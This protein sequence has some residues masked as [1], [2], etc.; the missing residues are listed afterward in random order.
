MAASVQPQGD[1]VT[2]QRRA[3]L[4]RDR[5]H[6]GNLASR[7]KTLNTAIKYASDGTLPTDDEQIVELAVA[8]ADTAARDACIKQLGTAEAKGAEDLWTVLTREAPPGLRTNPACLL[9]IFAR[10]RGEGALAQVALDEAVKDDPNNT[11]ALLFRRT[12]EMG[13]PPEALKD[14]LRA[15]ADKK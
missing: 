13:L 3:S 4:A 8:L 15:A 2:I 11:L 14:I 1:T 12:M 10:C 6:H 7:I 9:A 5:R